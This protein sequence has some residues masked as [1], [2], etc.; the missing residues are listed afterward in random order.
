MQMIS[1]LKDEERKVVAMVGEGVTRAD[2][3]L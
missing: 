1:K 3:V 2:E